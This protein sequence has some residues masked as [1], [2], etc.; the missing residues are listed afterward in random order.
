MVRWMVSVE[1]WVVDGERV[2]R[3]GG[4]DERE[5]EVEVERERGRV[6]TRNGCASPLNVQDEDVKGG[7]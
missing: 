6:R 2:R 7:G 1:G 3:S 4:G 5:V